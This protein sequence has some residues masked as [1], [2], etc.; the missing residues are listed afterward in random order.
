MADLRR[1]PRKPLEVEFTCKDEQGAGEL[2]FEG[3]DLSEGGAFLKSDVLLEP[4]DPLQI[5]FAARGRKV[6]AGAEVVWARRFPS[7]GQSA[8]MGVRFRELSAEDCAAL[9]AILAEP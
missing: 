1:H 2:S 5:E 8:G 7:Q 9:A 6:V 3:A 4:G